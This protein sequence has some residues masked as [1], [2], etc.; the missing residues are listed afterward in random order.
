[1]KCPNCSG[2]HSAFS[3]ACPSFKKEK[4][5]IQLKVTENLTFPQA[6]LKHA[7]LSGKSYADAARRGVG[8]RLVDAGTQYSEADLVPSQPPTQ[9]QKVATVASAAALRPSAGRKAAS[10]TPVQVSDVDLASSQA[11][12]QQQKTAPVATAVPAVPSAAATAS[13]TKSGSDTLSTSE[14]AVEAMDVSPSTSAPEASQERRGAT[15]RGKPTKP[16]ASK[17]AAPGNDPKT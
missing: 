2:P 14:T 9:Q 7:L 11:P 1:M 17:V 16:K 5:I 3:R 13:S 6:R 10:T 12:V 8:R 4:E 15:G